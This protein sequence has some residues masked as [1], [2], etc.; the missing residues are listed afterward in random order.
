MS[1]IRLV[2]AGLDAP[3]G[4]LSWQGEI[5]IHRG[6]KLWAEIHF[7]LED[8]EEDEVPLEPLEPF[9]IRLDDGEV[10][11]LTVDCQP[12]AGRAC[13]CGDPRRPACGFFRRLG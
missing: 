8:G 12:P 6:R 10:T 2:R 1:T 11:L 7:D 5:R 9:D 4:D 13:L 3:I